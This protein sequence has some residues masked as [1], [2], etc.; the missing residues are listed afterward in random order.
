MCK[1]GKALT[2]DALS[3]HASFFKHRTNPIRFAYKTI[4]EIL[5]YCAGCAI[6]CVMLQSYAND[7]AY[8]A[9]V[10]DLAQSAILRHHGLYSETRW[11]RLTGRIK[12]PQYRPIEIV[13]GCIVGS[14]VRRVCVMIKLGFEVVL[15]C[16]CLVGKSS[17]LNLLTYSNISFL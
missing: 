6:N 12:L 16:D 10:W 2:V 7:V 3:N 5:S 8:L 4:G 13:S 15:R 11:S 9:C 17:S 1:L 14:I